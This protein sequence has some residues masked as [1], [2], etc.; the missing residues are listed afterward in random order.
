[1]LRVIKDNQMI[2]DSWERIATVEAGQQIPSA[3][4]L[5]VPFSYWKENHDDLAKRTGN[6]A[7][8]LNGEDRIEDTADHLTAFS[9][10]ALDFPLYKDG[11]CYSHAR[12]LRDRLRYKGDIR[13]VGDV[14]R[15]QLFSMKR[16]GISS[17]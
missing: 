16:C 4:D 6:T 17:F 10:I 3:G 5:I 12:I 1:P 11:R 14:L 8:C 13:A 7:V 15:D 9:L 2:E